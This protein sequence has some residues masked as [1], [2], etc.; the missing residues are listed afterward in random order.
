MSFT[1]FLIEIRIPFLYIHIFRLPPNYLIACLA[2]GNNC[3]SSKIITQFFPFQAFF[4]LNK[5][6]PKKAVQIIH[7][8]NKIIFAH[9]YS[10]LQNQGSYNH[11]IH[12]SQILLRSYFFQYALPPQATL[13]MPRPIIFSIPKAYRILY[14]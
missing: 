12:F 2:Y 14:A 13:P 9:L 5:Q 3:T 10:L 6:I 8:F 1:F 11:H 4:L 7:N